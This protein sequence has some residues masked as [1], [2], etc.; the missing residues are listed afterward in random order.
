[1][2]LDAN[3]R[4]IVRALIAAGCSVLDLSGARVKSC[5]DLCV[6]RARVTVLMEIKSGV[7]G[8][9]RHQRAD[10]EHQEAWHARWRGG[11]VCVVRSVDEALRAVGVAP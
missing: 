3:H 10:Q 2:K 1:M 5:P 11:P 6:G 8:R 4:E 7:A 9:D